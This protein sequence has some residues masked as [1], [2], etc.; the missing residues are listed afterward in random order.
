MTQQAQAF[1]HEGEIQMII[2]KASTDISSGDY[3]VMP[4]N[5]DPI[6]RARLGGE[7]RISPVG[8]TWNSQWGAGIC[9]TDFT[10]NTV[11]STKYAAPTSDEALPVIRR[12]VVRLAISQTSGQKGDK[13]IYSSGATGAQVFKINNF[14]QDVAVGEIYEDFSGATAN[15]VQPVF[16]YEKDIGGRDIHFWLGNRVL[17][18]CKIKMHSV[19]TQKS[20]QV[21]AGATGEVNLLV[22]KGKLQ[23]VA[24]V[25]DLVVGAINPTGQ[26]AVRFY[27]LAVKA[28]VTGGAVAFTKET[29]TGPFSAFASW[30][31]SGISAGMMIPITWTSNMVPVALLVGWSNTQVSIGNNRILN[32]TGAFLPNGTTVVDH[33]K[34]YL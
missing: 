28:S 12:G 20:S 16:L 23:S 24:R 17:Q 29:C 3:V 1:D 30:T 31:N 8:A 13:V 26:S 33:E 4:R 18:G 9:D 14:R 15:D 27:W 34:W 32:L 2:P 6:S 5:S 10:T 25:T 21:N 11:G 22:I 19:N 7:S